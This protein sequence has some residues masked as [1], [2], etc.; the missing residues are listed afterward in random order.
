M[1]DFEKRLL[2]ANRLKRNLRIYKILLKEL[3]ENERNPY[4]SQYSYPEAL[5]ST[6]NGRVL[7]GE[8][9]QTLLVS[10]Y[11]SSFCPTCPTCPS[12]I[13]LILYRELTEISWTSWTP[14]TLPLLFP[15]NS[16]PSPISWLIFSKFN[17]NP[18]H[19]FSKCFNTF[20]FHMFS[21][22]PFRHSSKSIFFAPFTKLFKE[23][24]L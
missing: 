11:H 17:I 23:L 2:I 7:V 20:L 3:S 5:A 4:V 24:F 19:C 9:K 8:S 14:W 1:I 22:S 13:D 15:F 18:V 16:S 21:N 6:I 10:E 12:N